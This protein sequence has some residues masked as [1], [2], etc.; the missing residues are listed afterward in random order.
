MV[1]LLLTQIIYGKI[2]WR[3]DFKLDDAFLLI[4]RIYQNIF[5]SF[6]FWKE[7]VRPR[8]TYNM[9]GLKSFLQ[10][11]D[12]GQIKRPIILLQNHIHNR[13]EPDY[14][15]GVENDLYH[16]LHP[17]LLNELIG[18]S[19]NVVDIPINCIMSR[20]W[21]LIFLFLIHIYRILIFSI[22][23]VNINAHLVS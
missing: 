9:L 4:C 10:I 1:L 13:V 7:R 6:D 18:F 11:P 3:F 19:Q 20:L 21:S 22:Q 5:G 17:F 16:L 8:R 14:C 23:I 2:F 15:D 12:C